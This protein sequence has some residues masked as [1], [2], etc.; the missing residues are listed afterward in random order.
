[1]GCNWLVIAS[2]DCEYCLLP[3]G[4]GLRTIFLVGGNDQLRGRGFI[5][6]VTLEGLLL[7]CVCVQRSLCLCEFEGKQTK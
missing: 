6:F 4:R 7:V 3:V 2:P 5:R 1:M